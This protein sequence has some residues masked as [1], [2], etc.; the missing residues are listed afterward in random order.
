MRRSQNYR[1][2]RII[3]GDHCACH[4]F[5]SLSDRFLQTGIKFFLSCEKHV[6]HPLHNLVPASLQAII[7][8][9]L[10]VH[11][12]LLNDYALFSRGFVFG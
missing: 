7:Y 5:P 9:S 6:N 2:H 1:S 11:V 10:T 12:E 3:C 8:V 4:F